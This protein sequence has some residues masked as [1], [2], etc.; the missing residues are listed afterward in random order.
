[1]GHNPWS[2]NV[3][4][5]A[6]RD[7][8]G[9]STEEIFSNTKTP[10][11]MNPKGVAFREC[12]DSASNPNSFPIIIGVDVTGSMRDIPRFIIETKLPHMI[13]PVIAKGVLNPA[14]MFAAIGDFYDR[15]GDY[16]GDRSPLQ[17]G[18]FESGPKELLH[19][20]VSAHLE[21][22][23][24]SQRKESYHGLWHFA[25]HHTIHDHMEKRAQKGVLVTI[26]DEA[27]WDKITPAVLQGVFGYPEAGETISDKEA[28]TSALKLYDVFHIHA[29]QGAYANNEPIFKYWMNMLGERFIVMEDRE[30]IA[31][32]IATIVGLQHGIAMEDML[33][34]IQPGAKGS[35]SKALANVG[36]FNKPAVR[37]EGV[38]RL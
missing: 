15:S 22:N 37:K 17:V 3:F 38:L 12:R 11:D 7:F 14:I 32:L 34:A 1:M 30:N 33:A 31:D 9:K 19:W 25:G 10:K 23:G 29:N 5:V 20:L 21:G 26:G 6:S 24:Q 28:L 27:S 18:Q 13:E 36:S 2:E 35:V 16:P 4:N 8:V